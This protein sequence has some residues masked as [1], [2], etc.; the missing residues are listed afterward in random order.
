VS[1]VFIGTQLPSARLINLSELIY[2]HTKFQRSLTEYKGT[3]N[4]CSFLYNYIFQVAWHIYVH[5]Y[6]WACLRPVF[7][8]FGCESGVYGSGKR[9]CSPIL[10]FYGDH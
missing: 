3:W 8:C 9:D 5:A 2:M 1:S 4:R 7:V 10:T 6:I